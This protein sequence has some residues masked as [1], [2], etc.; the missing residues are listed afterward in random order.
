MEEKKDWII[1]H[2]DAD[3]IC[4][5]AIAYNIFKN[6]NILFSNPVNLLS[7]LNEIPSDASRIIV[8]DIAIID[9]DAKKIE[10]KI[11][12]LSKK[13]EIIYIDHHPIPEDFDIKKLQIVFIHEEKACASELIFRFFN[14]KLNSE[15]ERVMLIGAISDYAD[16][17]PFIEKALEKWDKRTLY[18]EAGIL[19]NGLESFR[20]NKEDKEKILKFLASGKPPSFHQG[21]IGAAIMTAYLEE[22]MRYRIKNNYKKIGE[23]SYIIDPKGPL[24][25]AAT[26][27]K[28]EG[29]TLVGIAIDIE[30]NKADMSIRTSSDKINLNLITKK[31]ANKFNGSGGGHPNATGAKIPK[32]N[33]EEFLK[34]FNEE[35]EKQLKI[36]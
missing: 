5:G 33:L 21:L 31:V 36:F 7:T 18:F 4:S 11:M 26:Y 29:R 23:V 14:D 22:E 28:S 15:M 20:K 2:G 1:T 10:E 8:S 6:S 32:I 3:G 30:N 17:T 13:C 12:Q 25:K 24:G 34:E 35:I 16:N 27:V 19:I 9:N